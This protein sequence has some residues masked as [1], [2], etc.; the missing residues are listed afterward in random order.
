MPEEDSVLV[1]S[2]VGASYS[3]NRFF[4][5]FVHKRAP[6][7]NH[8]INIPFAFFSLRWLTREK[9]III[10]ATDCC[11]LASFTFVIG[12][13]TAGFITLLK[14]QQAEENKAVDSFFIRDDG[15]VISINHPQGCFI[16]YLSIES[17]QER[18]PDPIF[19]FSAFYKNAITKLRALKKSTPIAEIMTRQDII[20]GIGNY[21][22]SEILFH[23]KIPPFADALEICKDKAMVH[24]L[25]LLC[26]KIPSEVLLKFIQNG[27][28][29]SY[30]N[31]TLHNWM[32][33]QFLKV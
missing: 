27:T 9:Q 14:K 6:A 7:F 16:Q 28:T 33:T 22:R 21:L 8:F 23:S 12:L 24:R 11:S 32:S 31:V 26:R 15:F 13:S 20:N 1:S 10:T 17:L 5:G 3:K 18:G 2:L 19:Q 25:L 29:H 4:S 30:F